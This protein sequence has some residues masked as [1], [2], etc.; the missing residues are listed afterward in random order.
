MKDFQ[1]HKEEV[2]PIEG[3]PLACIYTRMD[4]S[5]KYTNFGNDDNGPYWYRPNKEVPEWCKS[6]HKGYFD[7]EGQPVNFTYWMYWEDFWELL[8]NIPGIEPDKHE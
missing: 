1:W 2:R 7:N 6:Y 3:K 4:G 8:E 5:I